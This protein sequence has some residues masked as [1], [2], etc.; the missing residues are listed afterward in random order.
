MKLLLDSHVEKAI[1]GALQKRLR[2]VDVVHLADWREGSLLHAED[3][4]ILSA[5]YEEGRLWFTYDQQTVSDL[6]RQW[7][8]EERPH[9]GVIFGDWS[10]VPPND[11]RAVAAALGGLADEIGASDTTHLVRY[12]H[13]PRRGRISR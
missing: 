6:L 3:E 2:A 7:A 9:A 13:R 4:D 10:S 12:L 5:C 8:A 11:V 1:A